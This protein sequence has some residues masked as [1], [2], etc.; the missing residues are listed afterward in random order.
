MNPG[1]LLILKTCVPLTITSD[2]VRYN[3]VGC[4]DSDVLFGII[5]ISLTPTYQSPIDYFVYGLTTSGHLGWMRIMHDE[6]NEII[7]QEGQ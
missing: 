3:K 5:I 4:I 1:D 2:F 7:T 6:L